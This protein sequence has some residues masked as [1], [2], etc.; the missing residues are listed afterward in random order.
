MATVTKPIA[1]DESFNTT[2]VT[3]RNIADVLAEELGRLGSKT[4]SDV[5]YDNTD[6]G[7]VAENVQDALD[8]INGKIPTVPN[9]DI[10]TAV[11]EFSTY[12]GGLLSSLKV[13]LSPNQDLHGYD[14]PWVGG[15]RKNKLPLPTAE[16]KNGITLTHNADGSLTL[17]P[18]TATAT[19]YFDF[20]AGDFDSTA[21]AGYLFRADSEYTS[22]G[23]S[24]LLFRISGSDRAQLQSLNG[25]SDIAINDNGNGL[26]FALRVANG[27]V[28]PS[29]GI[30]IYPM[31][32]NSTETATFEPYSNICPISGHTEVDIDVSDGQATQEQVTVN[33]GGTYYSGTLDVVTGVFV[34]DTAKKIYNGTEVFAMATGTNYHQFYISFPVNITKTNIIC[35]SFITI[36]FSE[37]GQKT[38][39][40]VLN[41]P[42]IRFCFKDDDLLIPTLADFVTWLSAHN[43]EVVYPL[44]NP[45][46]IQ[47]SP[48]MVKALVG[49]N[50]LSAPLDGQE[51][52]ESKYKQAFTFDD[53]I[54][55]IQSLS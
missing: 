43:V 1:L 14:S 21:Y 47:L 8:E 25:N 51:I 55:Y 11:D 38:G 42:T 16:T 33:L 44:A 13:S 34:P 9:V 49:E 29:G 3:P 48:T 37:R 30:T 12:N 18:G 45:T 27:F 32:R 2:E 35:D 26:Y 5:M 7:L 31:L 40:A 28:I 19:T 4:A 52:T 24:T 20:F 50:H 10:Q 6:S 36:D 39:I 53:V 15:S 41:D 23:A 22:W 17:E 54:A 46:P